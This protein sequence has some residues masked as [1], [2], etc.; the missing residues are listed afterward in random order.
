MYTLKY[1][2]VIVSTDACR[3]LASV[4]DISSKERESGHGEAQ[5]QQPPSFGGCMSN[6]ISAD[7][8]GSI[9]RPVPNPRP[10]TRP[11]DSIANPEWIYVD[12]SMVA[13]ADATIH[14]SSVAARYGTSVF[15]GMCVYGGE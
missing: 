14:V 6:T 7:E 3:L 2:C 5:G 1:I 10:H 9:E 12:G 11:T 13:R 15:E 8:V 4:F